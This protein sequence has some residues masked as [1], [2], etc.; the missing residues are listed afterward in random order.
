LELSLKVIE[1]SEKLNYTQGIF[2][3]NQSLC[4]LLKK[5]GQLDSAKKICKKCINLIETNKNLQH[6]NHIYITLAN[7]YA[8]QSDY[9]SAV[10]I[11]RFIRKKAL[12]EGDTTNFIIASNNAAVTFRYLG[13]WDS[14][15]SVLKRNEE[16]IRM[17]KDTVRLANCI[18]IQG[19]I[20][21]GQGNV[22]AALEYYFKAL[23]TIKQLPEHPLIYLIQVNIATLYLEMEEYQKAVDLLVSVRKGYEAKVQ[24]KM[25]L[26]NM[27]GK[28]YQGLNNFDSAFCYY[29]K[30]VD[31]CLTRNQPGQA[32]IAYRFLGELLNQHGR[33]AEALDFLQKSIKVCDHK[34]MKQE[35][36]LTCN[37]LGNSLLNLKKLNKA[38]TYFSEAMSI[39]HELNDF[40]VLK[41][42]ANGLRYVNAQKRNFET[43]Y[44]YLEQ[45]KQYS[46]SLMNEENIRA[47]ATRDMEYEFNNEK[48]AIIQQQEKE[49]LLHRETLKRQ[50]L[51]RNTI[52][53]IC[54]LFIIT[55]VIIFRSYTIKKKADNEKAAL[56]KEIHHRVKNNL[57]IISGLLTIQTEYISDSNVI[58]AVKES[59][60]R[61]KAMALIHQ[62]LYQADN[63][64]KIDFTIYLPQ[65]LH[66]ISSVFKKEKEIVDIDVEAGGISFDIDKA[67]PLGLIITELVSNSFKYAFD[68]QSA[69]KIS[70]HLN[71]LSENNYQLPWQITEK[72]YRRVR[73]LRT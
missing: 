66:V 32:A 8:G 42:A 71:S 50:K 17:K 54:L 59:Q 68:G 64:T 55:S 37:S 73:I 72:D 60:S 33:Y 1:A 12:K 29:R 23:N 31:E 44:Y 51:I 70:V 9:D 15:L 3:G 35:Y 41:D 11:E 20:L 57:Q 30:S 22:K 10:I 6:S 56:M 49:R 7:I 36:A 46:D 65:L 28:A 34:K 21:Q 38:E 16:I 53:I 47:I 61:V 26:Y 62:L 24:G 5:R 14:S 45:Y 52:I 67:I 13:M 18:H 69:K 39:G 63:L 2:S 27:F 48:T 58:T 40:S 19:T 25:T 4:Y 43:A